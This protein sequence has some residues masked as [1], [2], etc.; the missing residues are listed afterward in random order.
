MSKQQWFTMKTLEVI[1]TRTY[2]IIMRD[3]VITEYL[4]YPILYH[5]KYQ[6]CYT[7]DNYCLFVC[8]VGV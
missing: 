4:V 5:S 6:H 2:V 3:F 7:F 8:L 1:I